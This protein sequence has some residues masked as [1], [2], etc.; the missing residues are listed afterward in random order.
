MTMKPGLIVVCAM[1]WVAL[2][3]PMPAHGG[4]RSEPPQLP[5]QLSVPVRPLHPTEVGIL[6]ADEYQAPV[7]EGV[8]PLDSP[9]AEEAEGNAESDLPAVEPPSSEVAPPA[10]EQAPAVEQPPMVP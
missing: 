5:A 8:E 4:R 10:A 6:V 9:S 7:V 2:G 3:A 1:L